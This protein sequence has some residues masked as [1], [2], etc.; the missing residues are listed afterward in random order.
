MIQ[1]FFRLIA[2]FFNSLLGRAESANATSLRAQAVES[3]AAKVADAQRGLGDLQ[4]AVR[5]ATRD[6]SRLEKEASH[7]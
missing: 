4:G 5:E 7:F 1:R 2:A 6:V 3:S